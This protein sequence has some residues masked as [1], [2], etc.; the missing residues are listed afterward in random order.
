MFLLGR[1]RLVELRTPCF[2]LLDP[3]RRER[4]ILDLVEQLLHRLAGFGGHDARPGDV[5]AMLGGVADRVPHVVDAAAV[6]QIDDELQLV[7]ALEVRHLGLIAR[8]HERLE[9]GLDERARSATEHGLL[10]E[11]VG[12]GLF[13]EC[14]LDH[15]GAR[16][17]DAFRVRQRKRLRLPGRVL[18]DRQQCRRPATLHKQ[19]AYAMTRRLRRD[20]R[21]ID[22]GRRFHRAEA[23]VEAVREHQH[24]AFGHVRRDVVV[25]GRCGRVGHEDHHHI[26]PLRRFRGRGDGEAVAFRFALRFARQRQADLHFHAAVLQ[27]QRVRM[28][29]RPVADNRHLFAANQIQIRVVVVIHSRCHYLSFSISSQRRGAAENSLFLRKEKLCVFASLRRDS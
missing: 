27:I 8:A 11:Q 19:L 16:H 9:A 29:L 26:G 18:M 21:D 6:H 17:A 20:H 3:L 14:R 4:A 10:A 13:G 23:D 12:F 28:A 25:H 22:V 7:Q 2:V 15:A 1:A 24:L 5:V